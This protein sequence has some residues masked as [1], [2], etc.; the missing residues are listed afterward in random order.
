MASITVQ[1]KTWKL[2]LTMGV[3]EDL[4]ESGAN[5]QELL[6][7]IQQGRTGPLNYLTLCMIRG[8]A[9]HP[10]QIP[11]DLVR[12]FP[13]SA[14]ADMLIACGEAFADGMRSEL[15]EDSVR[16]PVL[17]ELEKKEGPDA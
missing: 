16:D 7:E 8:A 15:A 4:E 10:E 3:L 11:A 9:E 6:Q 14:R 17:E 2:A 12:K 1:G 13:P 5:L